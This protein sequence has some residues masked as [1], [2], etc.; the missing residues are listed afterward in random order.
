MGAA[1]IHGDAWMDVTNLVSAICGCANAPKII[2]PVAVLY[3][4]SILIL[5]S[6]DFVTVKQTCI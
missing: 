5:L 1:L 4:C 6:D 3:T 2:S